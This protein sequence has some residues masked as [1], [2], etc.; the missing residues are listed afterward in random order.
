[1][2]ESSGTSGGF[3]EL[4]A[5][6]TT[7]EPSAARW[8]ISFFEAVMLGVIGGAVGGGILGGFNASGA[9]DIVLTVEFG[10]VIGILVGVVIAVLLML[11]SRWLTARRQQPRASA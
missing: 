9:V 7:V 8:S 3:A 5:P 6:V 11:L 4:W 1:M 2:I 10:A